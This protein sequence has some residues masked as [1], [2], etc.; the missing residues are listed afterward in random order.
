[1]QNTGVTRIYA[2]RGDHESVPENTVAAFLAAVASGANG[3][4]LDVRRTADG[5]LVVH[6][7]HV[8]AGIG[9]IHLL[10]VAD[11]PSDVALLDEAMG[12]AGTLQVNVEI[13]NDPDEPGHDPTGSLSHQVVALL[14]E[15]GDLERVLISS[16]DLAT[17]DAV[18]QCDPTVETGWLLGYLQDPVAAVEVSIAHGIGA[19]HPFVLSVTRDLVIRA[20]DVGLEVNTWTVNAREDLE[21]M[22]EIGVDIVIT[23]AVALALEVIDGQGGSPNG[24]LAPSL[25]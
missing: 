4:E 22:V 5:A 11:L 1:M 21:R 20:H 7:D 12:A 9:D 25:A 18:R 24:G 6:H 2:H 23:D 19:I 17:L 10:H 14:A 16:F 15:R 8:I 13:K 3:V